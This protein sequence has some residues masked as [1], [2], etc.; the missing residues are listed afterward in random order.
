MKQSFVFLKNISHSILHKHTLAA[1]LVAA[2]LF[3]QNT[4]ASIDSSKVTQ[5]SHEKFNDWVNEFYKESLSKG[6]R[7]E[8]LDTV[9]GQVKLNPK[10]V[11]FDRKQPFKT[12]SFESYKQSIVPQSR[13]NKA[14]KKYQQH[15]E[16]LDEIGQ[17]YGVQPRFIVALWAIESN[18][19]TNMGRYSI[20]DSL[21]TLSF[22]GRRAKFFRKE[23]FNAIKIIDEGHINYS[24]MIGSWA[25]AMGQTQFMPSSFLSLAVDYN[26]D[27]KKDIWSTK[28]DVFASI[29]NYLSKTKWD[30]SATWG[31]QIQLPK[32]FNPSFVNIK[33]KKT[34]SEWAELGVRKGDGSALPTR[35]LKAS[36][37]RPDDNAEEYYI[38]YGNYDNLLKWNRSLYFA[39]A[40]GLLSDK[41]ATGS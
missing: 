32:G 6:I 4:Y 31:R 37:V 26:N 9:L 16:L 23:L 18:F 13:I 15:K 35:D 41:I 33:T 28:E 12:R 21:A 3:G 17:R 22:E 39:T 30:D 5:F 2:C 10:V 40:V 7:K 11:S 38:V 14:N 27:G 29:A 36:I 8:T 25:G 20:P 24:E 19:G 1:C 34:L